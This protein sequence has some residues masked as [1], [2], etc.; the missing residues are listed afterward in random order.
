MNLNCSLLNEF[1]Y[2]FL[3]W[4]LTFHM[5]GYCS[6]SKG[7]LLILFC[8]NLKTFFSFSLSSCGDFIFKSVI[9]VR[10]FG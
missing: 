4:F 1:G 7:G 3:T 9:V 5:G 6:I 2:S 8:F 10:R